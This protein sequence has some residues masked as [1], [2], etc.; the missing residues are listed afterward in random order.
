MSTL[1]ALLLAKNAERRFSIMS[2]KTLIPEESCIVVQLSVVKKFGQVPAEIL[3][4]LDYWMD[5]ATTYK[6][7]EWWVWKTYENFMEELGKSESTITRALNVL[8]KCGVL[9]SKKFN[10]FKIIMLNFIELIMIYFMK[11]LE[12]QIL[13][14]KIEE[15]SNRISQIK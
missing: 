14:K 5:S 11:L 8:E 13:E 2:I 1:L 4:R 9:I 12:Y 15:Q 6:Q 7:N 10:S 3:S